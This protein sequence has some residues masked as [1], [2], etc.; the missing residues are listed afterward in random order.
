M[1]HSW[2]TPRDAHKS[3]CVAPSSAIGNH[4]IDWNVRTRRMPAT[5]TTAAHGMLLHVTSRADKKAIWFTRNIARASVA[6]NPPKRR[7][8]GNAN[9]NATVTTVSGTTVTIPDLLRQRFQRSTYRAAA[10]RDCSLEIIRQMAP[11]ISPPHNSSI[12]ASSQCLRGRMD[13]CSRTATA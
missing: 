7:G 4:S 11:R 5:R 8:R 12:P 6:C 13:S 1:R 2:Q 9:V 10:T 3:E